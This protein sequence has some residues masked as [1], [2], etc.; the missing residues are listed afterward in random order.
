[1]KFKKVRIKGMHCEGCV[2]LLTQ[3][4]KKVKGVEKV[5]INLREGT[6][7]LYYNDHEPLIKD[8]KAIVRQYGYDIDEKL[9]SKKKSKEMDLKDWM[10][11]VA[12]ALTFIGVY[13]LLKA[14]GV[15]SSLNIQSNNITFGI[16]FLMGII[17][18]FSTCFAIVGSIV[19]AF[20]EKYNSDASDATFKSSLIPNVLFQLGRI[21]TFFLLGGILGLVGGEIN[22]S[23][24]FISVYTI[25]IAIVMTFLGLNILGLLPSFGFK[26]SPK[27]SET[28]SKLKESKS[29]FAPFLLGSITFFLPCGFTQSMQIF[30]ITSGSFFRGALSLMFFA[31]GTLPVLLFVGVATSWTR[32]KGFKIVQKAMGILILVFAVATFQSGFALIGVNSPVVS[33]SVGQETVQTPSTT[34]SEQVVEMHVTYNGFEPSVIEIKK[35]IPVRWIIYGDQVTGCTNRIIVPSLNIS[36]AINPGENVITFTPQNDGVI[37]FSCWMGMVRGKFIVH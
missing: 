23:G 28:Y 33:S 30:A 19:I 29:K 15:V 4:L 18:S 25:L 8:A 1:M 27:I 3:E 26:I 6:A 35:G 37:N 31:L 36:K 34:D 22:I 14:S 21:L 32:K 7:K 20:N 16:S 12:I 13:Y 11:S 24:K 10:F 5:E 17:A 9:T 2:T